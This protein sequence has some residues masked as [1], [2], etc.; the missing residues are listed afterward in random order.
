MCYHSKVGV[1]VSANFLI[2]VFTNQ[3][4]N[5]GVVCFKV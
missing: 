2:F 3:V 1:S 4:N 5:A